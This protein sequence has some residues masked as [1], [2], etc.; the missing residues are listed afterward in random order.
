MLTMHD[1]DPLL[2]H[3]SA[4]VTDEG[5][6]VGSIGEVYLNDDSEAPAWVTVH[7]GLFGTKESFVPLEGATVQGDRLVVAY[8][9]DLIR[10]AP[11]IERDGHLGPE[12]KGVLYAHYGLDEMTATTATTGRDVEAG[13]ASGD[14]AVTR[15]RRGNGSPWMVRSEERLR[16]GTETHEAARV[17][18]RKYVVTEE[19]SR[20]VPL[21][22]EELL[23][24]REPITTRNAP[25]D[26]S[27]FQEE[28]VELVSHEEQAVILGRDTVLVE[29]VR[30]ARTTVTGRATVR[31]EVRKER[32]VTSVDG[33][34]AVDSEA[35][36]P[37]ARTRR[38]AGRVRGRAAG[39]GQAASTDDQADRIVTN[40][41]NPLL[42]GKN[43]RR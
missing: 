17:R 3:R 10:N 38:S 16:V 1:L 43:K 25:A 20:T 5:D 13:N 6:R 29:R 19:A 12:D 9:R 35:F 40:T 27:L 21:L 24:E 42:K 34:A 7:T 32:I 18:L 36:G 37:G 23:I 33:D 4:V 39:R 22:R 31:E 8:S 30:L 14:A 15:E 26:G 41:P 28:V 2:G 11:S